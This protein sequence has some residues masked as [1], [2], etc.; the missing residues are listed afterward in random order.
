MRQNISFLHFIKNIVSHLSSRSFSYK[1]YLHQK[2]SVMWHVRINHITIIHT[3]SFASSMSKSIFLTI[4]GICFVYINI[5][6]DVILFRFST[7]YDN[8]DIF[9]FLPFHSGSTQILISRKVKGTF[10]IYVDKKCNVGVKSV[11]IYLSIM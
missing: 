7:I 11:R 6:L 10:N 8:V 2:I 3:K 1:R 9:H 4:F 5:L